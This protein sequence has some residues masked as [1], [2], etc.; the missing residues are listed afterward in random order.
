[1]ALKRAVVRLGGFFFNLFLFIYFFFLFFFFTNLDILCMN[2]VWKGDSGWLFCLWQGSISVFYPVYKN[3]KMCFKYILSNSVIKM[4]LCL[5]LINKPFL[6]ILN[7]KII[8]FPELIWEY[9][10]TPL[11]KYYQIGC[12]F[13]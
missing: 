2:D 10:K 4:C 9:L 1:M 13:R 6:Q 12:F 3:K 5:G 7:F 11:V 8:K